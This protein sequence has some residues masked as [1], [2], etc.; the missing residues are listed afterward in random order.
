MDWKLQLDPE[1]SEAQLA[2]AVIALTE[3]LRLTVK[4]LADVKGNA[5]L[6]WFDDLKKEAVQIGKGTVA[7]NVSIEKDASSVRFGLEAVDAAFESF[8]RGILEKE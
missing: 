1:H 6:S 2:A 7:E 8:R 4:K 3:A 5:D